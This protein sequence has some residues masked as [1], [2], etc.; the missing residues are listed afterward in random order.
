MTEWWIA[1]GAG[2]GLIVGSFVAT[3]AVRWPEGRKTG[4]RSACDVCG[5]RL[6]WFE[7]V[8]LLSFTLARGR[9]RRCGA[10]IGRVHPIGEAL[11]ALVGALAFGLAPGIE[12]GLAALAG[13][14]LVALALIDLRAFW[15]P[16]VLTGLL[17]V[18]SAAS[19]L[20]GIEPAPE[21]RLIGGAAGFLVLWGIARTYR[22]VR[23]R[24][25]LGGGD[26][27]LFGAIGLWL[28]WESLPFVL[29][30]A[31]LI[32]LMAVATM[33]ARGTAVRGTTRLPFGSMLAAAAFLA[34][35]LIHAN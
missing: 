21:I 25:G 4:G 7:L 29:L 14:L 18:V 9:C 8:P 3:L 20:A 24:E 6:R 15:L 33:M 34:W 32:G 17:V 13:W 10:S 23:G 16:D 1:A 22:L 27:K 11:C 35:T 26:P 2:L 31:S 28:G 12:G 30:L 5:E 19:A